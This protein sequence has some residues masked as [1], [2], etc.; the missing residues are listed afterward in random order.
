[1]SNDLF[2]AF[3]DNSSN[4]PRDLNSDRDTTSRPTADISQSWTQ[5]GLFAGNA[6]V[7]Q[8]SNEEDDDFGD[9][10]DASAPAAPQT[11]TNPPGRPPIGQP[12]VTPQPG[13]KAQTSSFPPKA[14]S[15][16]SQSKK[17]DT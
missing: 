4:S 8:T 5:Q 10:E 3:G 6:S 1:M 11:V 9:F 13:P 2:A 14:P 7:P 16:A 15:Y 17:V 12:Y